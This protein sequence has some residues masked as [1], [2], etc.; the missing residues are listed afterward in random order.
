MAD[1]LLEKKTNTVF[2][3]LSDLKATAFLYTLV[4]TL[5]KTEAKKLH[6]TLANK[7]SEGN[8]QGGRTKQHAM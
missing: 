6:Q 5:G 4:D 1:S 2:D 3:K 8:V 7:Q